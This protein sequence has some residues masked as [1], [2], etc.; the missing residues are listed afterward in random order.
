MSETQKASE[1]FKEIKDIG[2]GKIILSAK[3][4]FR[5]A[6]HEFQS[7][8]DGKVAVLFSMHDAYVLRD[9]NGLYS[10]SDLYK[11]VMKDKDINIENPNSI[12]YVE[13]LV[14]YYGEEPVFH[15]AALEKVGLNVQEIKD[16]ILR[17]LQATSRLDVE[18]ERPM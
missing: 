17:R 16:D 7:K 3:E 5:G 2:W 18:V 15:E 9:A 11:F 1:L 4:K 13:L 14:E 8:T 6:A 10:L 12:D